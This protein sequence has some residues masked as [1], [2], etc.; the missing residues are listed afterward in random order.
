MPRQDVCELQLVSCDRSALLALATSPA[1]SRNFHNGEFENFLLRR[2]IDSNSKLAKFFAFETME[3]SHKPH[4][5]PHAGAKAEK[6]KAKRDA[7]PAQKGRNP[8]AFIM[9][10]SR[11]TE[12]AAR[13]STEVPLLFVVCSQFRCQKNGCMCPWSIGRPMSPHRLLLL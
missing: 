9:S 10:G 8:R 4:R 1:L 6:K 12:K 5:A 11:R 7:Q 2:T 3:E 13:R